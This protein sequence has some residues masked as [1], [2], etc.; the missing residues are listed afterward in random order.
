MSAGMAI[1]YS[2]E[3]KNNMNILVVEDDPMVRRALGHYLLDIG[4]M[5]STCCNGQEALDFLKENRNIDLVI[6][7]MIMPVLSGASLIILMQKYFPLGLPHIVVMSAVKGGE[8]FVKQIGIPY[9]HFVRK[10]IDFEDLGQ[11]IVCWQT[12]KAS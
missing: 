9:D 5:V 11:Q 3:R 6:V 10:P 4:H 7:D 1:S 12:A 2:H 8:D